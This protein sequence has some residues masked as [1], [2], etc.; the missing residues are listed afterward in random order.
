VTIKKVFFDANIFNDV[1]DSRRKTHSVSKQ[2]FAHAVEEKTGMCTSCDVATNIYYITAKYTSKENALHAIDAV[3]EIV[4]IIPFGAEELTETI[5]LMRKDSDYKDMEDTI[6]YILALQTE[7]DVIVSNDK[8]FVSK[9]IPC[10]DSE[11]F[12][13]QFLKA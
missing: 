7:C 5:A 6:Q 3:K 13:K 2:A 4:E 8:K 10:M 9:E 12:V 11:T 1:F